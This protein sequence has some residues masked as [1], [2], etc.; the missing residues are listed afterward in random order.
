M[1]NKPVAIVVATVLS[2]LYRIRQV[3]IT[4]SL[5]LISS[6]LISADLFPSDLILWILAGEAA[7][8]AVSMAEQKQAISIKTDI[9]T[10]V[11]VIIKR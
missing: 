3:L 11:A 10:I 6:K 5:I 7:V 9:I 1:I 8:K 4:F 2:E